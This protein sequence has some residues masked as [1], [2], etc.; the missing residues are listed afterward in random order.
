MN[1]ELFWE[2]CFVNCRIGDVIFIR[3]I[4]PKFL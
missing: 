4:L 3:E 2:Y 1:I